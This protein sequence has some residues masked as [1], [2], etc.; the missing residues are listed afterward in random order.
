[1]THPLKCFRQHV[2]VFPD[3]NLVFS[4]CFLSV[5]EPCRTVWRIRRRATQEKVNVLSCRPMFQIRITARVLCLFASVSIESF[6]TPSA[7]G[8]VGTSS[9]ASYGFPQSLKLY[10]RSKVRPIG[11]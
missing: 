7:A 5:A 11:L 8:H 1:M 3:V 2:L 9:E 10:A 6:L 4:G